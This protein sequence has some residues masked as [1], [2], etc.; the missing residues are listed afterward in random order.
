MTKS[1]IKFLISAGVMILTGCGGG[2][3]GGLPSQPETCDRLVSIQVAPQQPLLKGVSSD[4]LPTGVSAQYEATLTYCDGSTKV[5]KDGVKWSVSNANAT[6][7]ASGIVST[8]AVGSVQIIAS[9]DNL[10]GERTLDISGNTLTRLTVSPPSASIPKGLTQS[11]TAQGTYSDGTTLDVTSLVAWSSSSPAVASIN[12]AGIATGVTEGSTT[13]TAML[14]GQNASA[15]LNVTAAVLT[16]L[17]ITPPSA[18]IP[19]GLTQSYT[20]QGTY[21]DGSTLDVTSLVAWSSSSPAV[22]SINTAGIATGVTE[23]STTVTVMLNGQNA[24]ANLNV[25]AAVLTGLAI[26]PPSATIP[27]GLT[28]SYTVQGTYSDGSTL[29]VTS[30]VAWSS[31]SPAVASIN[32]AGIATGV[33]EGSTTVTA[34]LN[35]QNASANLN[36]TAAVLTGLAITPP[37]ATIPKG[38]TQSYTAQGTYSDGSTLDVTSL[39]AWSSSSPA[40]ASINAAG[41]ATGVTAGS[42]MITALFDSISATGNLTVT[43]QGSVVTWGN[44]TLGGD[45]SSV[46]L[47]NIQTVIGNNGA[48]AALKQNGAVVTWGSSFSGGDSSSVEPQLT[49]VQALFANPGCYAMAALKQDGTVVTWGSANSGGDSSA[50]QAQLTNVQTINHNCQ[51]M[52]ALKQDGTV[53]TWGDAFSGGDSSAVQAQLTNVQTIFSSSSGAFAALK[54]DGTVVTWGNAFSGG[55]SSAVQAQLTNVQTIF[56]SDY[57]FAALKQDG[58]VVTWGSAFSG[59]DSSAVQAQLINVQTIFSS[60]G[61]FAALKQGGTVVTWG[62]AFSGGDSSAV[63]AQLT[64][65]QTIFS[66]PGVFAALKQDGTVVTWGNAFS[67]GDSSAV[68]AQLTNVQTIFS[69]SNAFAALKQDGTVVTWGDANSGGD[70]SS[71]QAQLT[72]VQTIFSSSGAFAAL[73]QDGTVVTWGDAN[74]GGDSSA[75]QAQLTN[76]QTIFSNMYAFAVLLGP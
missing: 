71:V 8:V 47:T 74:N 70:S 38:L 67:G 25:T 64:N 11:Y 75:V 41:I 6:I 19:K 3:S 4:Q 69:S 22:A 60:S 28:Q 58:T 53:V 36:V 1:I 73:K 34:M 43:N 55:D 13:V 49:N 27:K 33:T 52:A 54:Q 26:T 16:G 51:A 66:S 61:A 45:S 63:Q 37:S 18:T 15:N 72:N 2:N 23:G 76:V 7:S 39:V 46:Q 35:G 40:V 12:A 68:Q 31:S 30:L 29:D 24:S 20:A 10:V 14:N 9:L 32:T 21:S 56:S 17:T 44:P 65:V 48:Y 5:T 59:G 57:A 42:T 50:V 62:D